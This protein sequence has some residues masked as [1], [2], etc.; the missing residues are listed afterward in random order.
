MMKT[1]NLHSL[2]RDGIQEFDRCEL[3]SIVGVSNRGVWRKWLIAVGYNP[4]DLKRKYQWS[5][6]PILIALKLFLNS[7]RGRHKHTY[8]D[9]LELREEN[10]LNPDL[11]NTAKKL[12]EKLKHDYQN[13]RLA[14]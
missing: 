14:S 12:T 11:L 9:F 5:D 10:A 1:I 8:I 7:K 2:C 4:D 13:N 6:V 3:Q